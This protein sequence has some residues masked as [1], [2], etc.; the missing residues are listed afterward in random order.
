MAKGFGHGLGKDARPTFFSSGASFQ[1][2]RQ[3]GLRL[4]KKALN[5]S[6]ASA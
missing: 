1:F 4:L 5:P 3:P 6:W 2:R